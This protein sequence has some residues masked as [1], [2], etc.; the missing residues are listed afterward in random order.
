MEKAFALAILASLT[1]FNVA[2]SQ[3]QAFQTTDSGVLYRLYS[4]KSGPLAEIGNYLKY[5]MREEVHA[6]VLLSSY[7]NTPL[8]VRVQP[9]EHKYGISELFNLVR[10]GDSVDVAMP[11]DSIR[12]HYGGQ[13]PSFFQPNDTLFYRIK[14]LA[15][16]TSIPQ[17][18]ADSAQ[19]VARQR[20]RESVAIETYLAHEQ[21]QI[22]KTTLGDYVRVDTIGH[23]PAISTGKQVALH[24]TCSALHYGKIVPSNQPGQVHAPLTI[25]I[26]KGQ[27]VPGMEDGLRQFREGGKGTIYIPAFLAYDAA[28]GPGGNTYENLRFEVEIDKVT[29]VAAAMRK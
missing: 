21:V 29:T 14:I 11:V 8:Y 3:T 9:I 12:R 10:N 24:Y 15:V 1:L 2:F 13:L 26:G 7:S 16:F 5:N 6:G 27:A 19:E 28:F 23:G 25:V 4:D 17:M 22:E 20:K 18:E